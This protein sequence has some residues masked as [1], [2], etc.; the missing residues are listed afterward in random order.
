M[1]PL[2][3]N[4]NERKRPQDV[5]DADITISCWP[6]S[7]LWYSIGEKEG[8][9]VLTAEDGEE[10]PHWGNGVLKIHGKQGMSCERVRTNPHI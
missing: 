2:A 9:M 8:G 10:S 6:E 5:V 3:P 4:V 7:G 1:P